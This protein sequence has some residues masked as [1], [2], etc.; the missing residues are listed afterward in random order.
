MGAIEPWHLIIVLVVVLL[1]LGP[2]RLP[3]VGRSLG[4]TIREF[5]KATVEMRESISEAASPTA[6]DPAPGSTT[7]VPPAAPGPTPGASA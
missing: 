5:R 1:V 7:G 4:E 3:E 6:P 2:K